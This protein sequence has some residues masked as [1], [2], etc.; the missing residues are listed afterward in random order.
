MPTLQMNGRH[1]APDCETCS[2]REHSVFS[3]MPSSELQIFSSGKGCNFYASG[4]VI[5]KEGSYPSGLF[6]VH[7]GKIK[8]FKY[9]SEGR[10]QIIR[11]AK[12]GDILGYKSLITNEPYSAS[13]SALDD[14]VIF[15][16]L[17]LSP[18]LSLK[19]LQLLTHELR[20]A[21]TRMV[22]LAQKSVRERLAEA[23]LIL[24]ETFGYEENTK[25][26][27]VTLTR[28]EIANI[29]GTATESIIRL[30]SEFKKDGVIELAG[31]KIS[32]MNRRELVRTANIED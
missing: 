32:V 26:L 8:I 3:D 9:G 14:T 2:S 12:E 24:E 5:F 4:D 10:E 15:N 11:F 1:K 19:M 13:A 17:Q 6:C 28:E 20:T 23:L 22:D 16:S 30:L 29:V 21:E 27:N 18:H 25:I 7:K 31:R